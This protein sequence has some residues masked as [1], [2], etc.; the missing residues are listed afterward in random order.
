MFYMAG[1]TGTVTTREL[2]LA[3][4]CHIL[5]FVTVLAATW[6]VRNWLVHAATP[7]VQL[8]MCLS[9]GS[10]AGLVTVWCSASSRRVV[11]AVWLHL[12][13]FRK[14]RPGA[15]GVEVATNP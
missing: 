12:N 8:V 9:A 7:I 10:A 14:S 11:R 6:L 1:R 15:H 5:V 4:I 13:D 2:W 3:V